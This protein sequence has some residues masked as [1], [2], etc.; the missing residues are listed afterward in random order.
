MQ[1]ISQIQRDHLTLWYLLQHS[2]RS[3]RK[4]LQHFGNIQDAIHKDA[5]NTWQQLKL[6]ANHIQRLQHYHTGQGQQDF[7]QLLTKIEQHTDAILLQE[8]EDYPVALLPYDDSPPILFVKGQTDILQQ[9][10]IAMVGSRKPSSQGTQIAYDFAHYFAEQG[11]VVTSGLAIGIDTASHHGAI[12]SGQSIAVIATGLDQCYPAENQKLWQQIIATGG[13]IVTEFLPGTPPRKEYFPHRNRIISGL[14]AGTLVVEA[15]LKSGSLITAQKAADQGKQVFAIPGHIYSQFHQGCHQL[16]RE[17]AT[18]VDHPSQVLSDLNAFHSSE[19]SV[20][21]R[22]SVSS[23]D[24][25]VKESPHPTVPAH[26]QRLYECLDW[27]GISLDEL[28]L[29]LQLSISELTIA[30]VELELL[31]LCKQQAGRYLR[32]QIL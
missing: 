16:I 7:Q 25:Q 31:G 2:T 23:S 8:Q 29:K 27:V 20:P 15:N 5:I 14:S 26:L 4:L 9:S 12:T 32:C 11:Y 22:K 21:V 18:L 13:A 30:L 3:Y 28:A 19:P 17:G 1:Q 24:M 10:Q 6:H